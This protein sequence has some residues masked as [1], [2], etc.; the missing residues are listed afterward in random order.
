MVLTISDH[1]GMICIYCGGN[2][3][4]TNS[5]HQKRLNQVWRRRACVECKAIFTTNERPDLEQALSLRRNKALEPFSREVLLVS[6]YDSLKHRKSAVSDAVG[7]T[8]TIVS[9]LSP[10][11]TDATLERD[12]LATVA[13]EVLERFD[14]TAATIYRAFH[15]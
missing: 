10:F 12:V 8:T 1:M 9:Q 4:V 5:R 3:Q 7:L 13:A 2:T 6:V 15:P 14:P 11:I